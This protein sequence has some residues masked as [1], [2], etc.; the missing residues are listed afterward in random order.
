M[1]SKRRIALGEQFHILDCQFIR[2]IFVS[3]TKRLLLPEQILPESRLF[4]SKTCKRQS[5][6]EDDLSFSL[7]PAVFDLLCQCCH[8]QQII[9]IIGGLIFHKRL[10]SGT[11][12]II[13][14]RIL[15]H[16]LHRIW[17]I[18]IPGQS[19]WETDMRGFHGIIAMVDSYNHRLTSLLFN[20]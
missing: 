18:V 10:A 20:F 7:C 13:I 12:D 2:F 11:A 8:S 9:I 17:L 15:Q 3:E 5:G 19:C 16:I 4:P 6:C 14:P 1:E